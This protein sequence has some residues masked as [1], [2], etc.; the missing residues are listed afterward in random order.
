MNLE[1]EQMLD[2]EYFDQLNK[3]RTADA[4]VNRLSETLGL[5]YEQKQ[6]V[7]YDLLANGYLNVRK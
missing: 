3:I 2:E 5:S 7:M 6:M 4:L 1:L